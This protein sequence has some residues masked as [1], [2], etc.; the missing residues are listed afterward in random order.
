MRWRGILFLALASFSAVAE[1]PK[2]RV[3][4]EEERV[5]FNPPLAQPLQFSTRLPIGI[6]EQNR[7]AY[8]EQLPAA[9]E[10]PPIPLAFILLFLLL[11]AL[12]LLPRVSREVKKRIPKKP[13]RVTAKEKA[14]KALEELYKKSVDAPE[15]YPA[16]HAK[17]SAIVRLFLEEVSGVQASK[18]TTQELVSCAELIRP[19]QK[20]ALVEFLTTL[21]RLNFA[22][23]KIS[24]ED[25]RR[26][27]REAEQIIEN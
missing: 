23:C 8:M 12:P 6:S 25:F 9:P 11:S 21:D 1:T 4:V 7:A 18:M 20:K 10:H 22:D 27:Y 5:S 15:E 26:T 17:A 2:E 14:R 19:S 24:E 13:V 3:A 16:Y